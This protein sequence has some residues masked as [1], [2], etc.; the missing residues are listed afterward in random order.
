MKGCFLFKE[1]HQRVTLFLPGP[2]LLKR[3]VKSSKYEP[4]VDEVHLIE[5]NSQ[6]AHV[7][8]PSGRETTISLKHLAP[9]GKDKNPSLQPES[10]NEHLPNSN[11]FQAEP[12]DQLPSPSNSPAIQQSPPASNHDAS[13]SDDLNL[14]TQDATPVEDIEPRRYP[15]RTRTAPARLIDEIGKK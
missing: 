10:V 14:S 15:S 3:Q 2:V 13:S 6:Y 5:A 7:R 8:F 11:F 4:L 12:T 9:I 1:G